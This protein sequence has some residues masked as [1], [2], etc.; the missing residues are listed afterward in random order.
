MCRPQ[1]WIWGLVPIG[2][3]TAVA[4]FFAAPQIATELELSASGA[5]QK[6]GQGW[7]RVSVEGRNVTLRGSAPD[8]AALDAA[9]DAAAQA[10]GVRRVDHDVVVRTAPR[11]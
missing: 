6:A 4:Y 1:K 3:L 11:N 10:R 7:A 9:V 2:F 8:Q 5:L